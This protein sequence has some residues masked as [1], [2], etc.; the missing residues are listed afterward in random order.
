[1]D[2]KK[3]IFTSLVSQRQSYCT[4]C[5]EHRH[6]ASI[7]ATGTTLFPYTRHTCTFPYI[8]FSCT[9][10]HTCKHKY[11][12][13]LVPIN[14]T[15]IIVLL[16]SLYTADYEPLKCFSLLLKDEDKVKAIEL[17]AAHAWTCQLYVSLYLLRTLFKF[18]NTTPL[19]LAYPP[20]G[21][22]IDS[23]RPSTS[24]GEC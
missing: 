12:P 23:M 9:H 16:V 7:V 24:T 11:S 4:L 3:E 5:G 21:G 20:S 2:P 17:K 22:W 8:L 18:I 14:N 13:H 1:M 19:C 15:Y 10:K 6:D